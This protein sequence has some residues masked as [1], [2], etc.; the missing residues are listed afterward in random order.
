MIVHSLYFPAI[1]H[2][3]SKIKGDNLLVVP[4]DTLDTRQVAVDLKMEFIR[5]FTGTDEHP[6]RLDTFQSEDND[7]NVHKA[8][9]SA[10]KVI[11]NLYLLHQYNRIFR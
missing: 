5:N 7:S 11:D 1:H 9:R 10:D 8:A 6:R 4:V 3:Y 2:W